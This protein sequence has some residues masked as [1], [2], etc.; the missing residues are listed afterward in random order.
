MGFY[1]FIRATLSDE[2][3]EVFG[4]GNQ[5]R[6]FTFVDDVVDAT[7]GAL[8]N[9]PEGEALNVGGGSSVTL[10]Q[11]LDVLAQA[12]G[13]PVKRHHIETQKGD[14]TDTLSDNSRA[15]EVLGFAP[16]VALY[17]GLARQCEWM[18]SI[19]L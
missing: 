17:D 9:G 15:R 19:D 11:A 3:V 5:T 7:V 16:K 6:D 14:V 2:S 13:R 12:L 10:N 4:D 18:R 8:E 1:K